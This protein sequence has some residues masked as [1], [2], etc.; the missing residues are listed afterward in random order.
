MNANVST[1]FYSNAILNFNFLSLHAESVKADANL[2]NTDG[3]ICHLTNNEGMFNVAVYDFSQEAAQTL[4][5]NAVKN[6]TASGFVD[7]IYADQMQV[8]AEHGPQGG[9]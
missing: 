2:R 9:G 7:G 1:V 4:W 6:V 8:F 5:V 3:S